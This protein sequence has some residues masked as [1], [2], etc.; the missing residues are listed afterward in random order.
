MNITEALE[1]IHSVCWKG[2]RPGLERTRELLALMGN[3]EKKLKF[4]HIAGTNGKGSTASMSANILL[5]A[6]YRVGLYTS[7]YIFE[8]NERMRVN[9]ENISNS[10]LAEITRAIKKGLDLLSYSDMSKSALVRKL[11]SRDFTPDVAQSAASQLEIMGYIDEK[12]HALRL[13]KSAAKQF[14]GPLAISDKLRCKGFE[15]KYV[16]HAVQTL[17]KETDFAENLRIYAEQKGLLDDIL[18]DGDTKKRQKVYAAL[19]RRGFTFE[20]ISQLRADK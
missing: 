1:Y 13:A 9:G 8:F 16:Q 19:L 18:S 6:G 12:S 5:K 15:R 2:S 4:I 11:T 14:Y 10:E 17:M 3:P 7:P 20:H